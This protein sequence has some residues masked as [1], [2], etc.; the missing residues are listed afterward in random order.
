MSSRGRPPDRV[1]TDAADRRQTVI[2]AIRGAKSRITLSLFRCTDKNVL[3]ELARAVDRGVAVEVLVTSRAGGRKKKLRKLWKALEETGASIHPYNDPV[4][5]YHAKYLVA[6][7][8]PALIASL[9]FTRKCFERTCD[10][11]VLTYDPAVVSGLRDLMAADRDGRPLPPVSDRLIVGPELAR[12]QLTSILQQARS[13]IQMID[14]KLSDPDMIA[15]LNARRNEGLIVGTHTAK[16]IN[17]MKSHG[18]MLL[19]DGSLA[20]VGSLALAALSLDF[21]RE[22]AVVVTEPAA[23]KA[24][25]ELMRALP[26]AERAAAAAPVPGGPLC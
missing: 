7:D 19:V 3:D 20:V 12:R 13:T 16:R 4:V 22:V 17:D 9:N 1:I 15:L 2:D 24:V 23:V 11:I 25:E 8:G 6:D 18:K 10:A 26:A 21:R 5:K 14:A